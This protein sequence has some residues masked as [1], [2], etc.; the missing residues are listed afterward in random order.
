MSKMDYDPRVSARA[1]ESGSRDALVAYQAEQL[2][3]TMKLVAASPY[4]SARFK[5]TG[6]DPA[7]IKHPDE[8]YAAPTLDKHQYAAALADSLSVKSVTKLWGHL[9]LTFVRMWSM[10]TSASGP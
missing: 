8:L 5:E 3:R 2:Q 7:S 6:F 10:A 4:W 9:L 1:A